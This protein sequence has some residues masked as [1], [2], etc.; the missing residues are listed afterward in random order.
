MIANCQIENVVS[1]R[2]GS[3]TQ[4]THV[5]IHVR[6]QEYSSTRVPRYSS[7]RVLE[8][9]GTYPDKRAQ[10]ERNTT[11]FLRHAADAYDVFFLATGWQSICFMSQP[12]HSCCS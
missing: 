9:L 3:A 5:R 11:V 4:F 1:V 7:T 10:Q 12:G 8:Y 2:S 6:T